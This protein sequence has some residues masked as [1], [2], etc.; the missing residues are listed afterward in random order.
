MWIQDVLQEAWRILAESAVFILVG[1]AIAAVLHVLL[2]GG[3]TVPYLSSLGTRSV[4]L[5]SLVGLPL[6]LCSC[7]VLPAAVALRKKGASKGATLSFL[8]ST[9]ETSITSILLTYALLGPLIAVFRPVAAFCSAVAAGLANNFVERRFPPS[10]AAPGEGGPG[11]EA[12]TAPDQGELPGQ[13]AGAEGS[14]A[15]GLRFAF[16]EVFDDIIG[17]LIVGLLV[18]ALLNV[19]VPPSVMGAV[20]GGPWQSMLIMLVL[21]VPLYVC[22]EGST[23][24]AAA[25]IAG[26]VNP[27]AALVFL[28]VGPATN[29]G[30]LGVLSKQLGRRTIVVYLISISVVALLMGWVLNL[31]LSG[32]DITALAERSLAEPLVPRSVKVLGAAVFLALALMSF[33][34]LRYL[35]RTLGWLDDRLPVR[36][37]R[38]TA[39]TVVA[40]LLI[41]AYAGSGFFMI[42][43]GEVG[44]VKR[45]GQVVRRDLPPGLY[46]TWP[47]PIGRADRE[48]VQAVRRLELGY[49]MVA[50]SEAAANRL[51]LTRT[52]DNPV[53][54]WI[55]LGDENIV[56]VKSAVH[57]GVQEGRAFDYRYANGDVETLVRSATLSALRQTLATHVVDT[58]LTV[59]REEAEQA[60]TALIGRRLEAC[61]TGVHCYQFRFLDLHAPE[62]VHAAFRDVA[63]AMEDKAT[64]INRAETYAAKTIPLARGQAT[65]ALEEGAGYARRVV[66]ESRGRADRFTLRYEEY[67]KAKALTRTRL[68]HE[69]IDRVLPRMNKY[70]K[71]PASAGGELEIW[72]TKPPGQ[73]EALPFIPPAA[74]GRAPQ[75][76]QG[77]GVLQPRT[78]P[79]RR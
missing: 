79:E 69:M 16:V 60:I 9:P 29:I 15:K 32:S 26:G 5:A 71:P 65:Q 44:F 53:E 55:L 41:V 13:V 54:S 22:A 63:S 49:S 25:F 23:P 14:F 56:N 68:Y 40:L 35:D 37:T 73:A 3:R 74:Q 70:V 34:R 67:A 12:S 47:Y 75:P 51:S 28:L 24:I 78:P 8:I 42:Q 31:I 10:G 77:F 17:W 7:S 38:G 72:F 45:F 21:G 61:D 20:F 46:Y 39:G 36:A 62:A 59:D 1:F 52:T 30:S 19:L 76:P 2:R 64:R 11:G 4:F 33:G 50:G 6:P 57:Y 18:A 48:A 66:D 43:P 27:G 58:I